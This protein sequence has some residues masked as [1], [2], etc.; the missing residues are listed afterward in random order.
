M[1]TNLTLAPKFLPRAD[2]SFRDF[3]TI[4]WM[5]ENNNDR[6]EP[7]T[8]EAIERQKDTAREVIKYCSNISECR[9]VQVLRHFGQEFHKRDCQHSCDNCLDDRLPVPE[10]AT[11]IANNAINVLQAISDAA[12][13]ITQ[14]QLASVLRGSNLSEI[15]K[16]GFTEISG[17]GTCKGLSKELMDVALGKLLVLDI[18]TISVQ[19]QKTGFSAEYIEVRITF[20]HKDELANAFSDRFRRNGI[21]SERESLLR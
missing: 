16:R 6:E 8:P 7:L 5:I 2:Y 18:L 12:D 14:S 13:K 15:R 17:F 3:M 21:Q 11:V 20:G 9:R 1:Y 19:R 10:D 4:C